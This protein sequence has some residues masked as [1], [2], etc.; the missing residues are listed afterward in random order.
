MKYIITSGPMEM[1]IDSVRKIEN[2]SSGLLGV[3]IAHE[4]QRREYDDIIY[5]H[6]QN[7]A[8]PNNV[9]QYQISNHKQLLEA[10]EIENKGECTIIHAMAIS[11]YKMGGSISLDKLSNLI[12]ENN[13][14]LSTTSDVKQLIKDNVEITSKLSSNEDQ[15]LLFEKEI[16]V[17]DQIKK[18]N[19]Q[20]TL[21]GF[22]LLSNV[23][24]SELLLVGNNIRKRADCDI[25]VANIKEEVSSVNHKAYIINGEKVIE[26]TT[27]KEIANKLISLLEE[28]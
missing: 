15:V 20:A 5:I 18:M 3:A 14:K 7:A 24:V 6:T 2:S 4:L 25:V 19:S 28:R 22:K 26:A 21:V 12:I 23:S 8:V 11:D 9:K 17:I 16:K 1:E 27:K 13:S 10:L